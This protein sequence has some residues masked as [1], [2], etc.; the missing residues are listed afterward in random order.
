MCLHHL[1]NAMDS[2]VKDLRY[3]KNRWSFK[4]ESLERIPVHMKQN[5][6]V[7]FKTDQFHLITLFCGESNPN[8]KQKQNCES[9]KV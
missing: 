3:S 8:F 2:F 5:N 7:F 4:K 9:G 6:N 1:H